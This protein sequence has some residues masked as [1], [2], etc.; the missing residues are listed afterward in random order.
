MCCVC[1]VCSWYHYGLSR[2]AAEALLLS[3]GC[4]GS[5]LL[6]TSQ[7]EANCFA[8]SSVRAKDSVNSFPSLQDFMCH[9]ANQ[10]LRAVRQFPYP[11]WVEEP[12][13][14]ESVCVHTA[15]QSGRQHSD[16]T[17]VATALGTKEG[18]LV[19]QGSIIKSWKQRWFTL[20]RNQLKYF[21][22]KMFMEPIRTLDL[23]ACSAVQFDYSRERINCFCLVFPE[24]ADEWIRILRWK[25]SQIRRG[26]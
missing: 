22:D 10:P 15:I 4:D 8:L 1:F 9:I 20:S 12:P 24:Q 23:T 6:R 19:K 14:Y 25:L 17:P 18:Y 5:F 3:N 7:H 26:R 13:I 11:R 16:L 2:H 21:K